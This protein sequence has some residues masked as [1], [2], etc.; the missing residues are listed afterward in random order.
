MLDVSAACNYGRRVPT[1]LVPRRLTDGRSA[2]VVH[3]Q[4]VENAKLFRPTA[5]TCFEAVATRMAQ[6]VPVPTLHGAQHQCCAE[7]RAPSPCC[8][9]SYTD[10][11][12]DYAS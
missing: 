1:D 2:G 4:M 3:S 9:S 12:S 10:D 5:Y 8:Q 6:S 11:N 7:S